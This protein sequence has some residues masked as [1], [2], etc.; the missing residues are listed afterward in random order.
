MKP[1]FASIGS[2]SNKR[3]PVD[4]TPPNPATDA[5]FDEAVG[6]A[7]SATIHDCPS[8][9]LEYTTARMGPDFL[10]PAP[11]CERVVPRAREPKPFP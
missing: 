9:L 1:A 4:S 2:K 7:D 3:P 6:C 8:L 5:T 10:H 11:E